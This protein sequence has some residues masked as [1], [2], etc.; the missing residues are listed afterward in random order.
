MPKLVTTPQF[1]NPD[2]AY[3]ALVEARRAL[4]DAKAAELDTRLVLILANHIGDLDVLKEAIAL[5]KHRRKQDMSEN[6]VRFPSGRL[7]ATLLVL[8]V[9][10]WAA[11]SFVT[12]PHLQQLAGGLPPFDARLRGY[13]YEEARAL[14]LALGA[15][16]ARITSAP[17]SFS[18]LF[19]RRYTPPSVCWRCGG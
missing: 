13:G 9:A 2:A 5:A 4:P 17:S 11:L 7:V 18:T 1:A 10:L 8:S 3:L 16:G 15:R 6:A 14:L 19:F 12:V